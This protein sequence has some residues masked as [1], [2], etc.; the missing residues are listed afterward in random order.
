MTKNGVGE[1]VSLILKIIG[2]G[3]GGVVVVAG[4]AVVL[5]LTGSPQSCSERVVSQSPQSRAEL[6]KKWGD[7]KRRA[8]TGAAE[9][10]FTETEVTSRGIEYLIRQGVPLENLQVYF[11][12]QGYADAT[13]TFVGG[14]PAVDLLVRGTL[15][16]SGDRPK[17][18]IESVPAGNLPG[19]LPLE[20]FLA[21]LDD[22]AKTLNLGVILTSVV[23]S[24]KQVTLKGGP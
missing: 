9:V 21:S 18:V 23:F 15:D 2:A 19:F 22:E 14:G 13:A 4:V 1:F 17:V 16:I 8:S 10:R 24:E 20:K 5:V 6:Q 11:C 3:I 12:E 7:F